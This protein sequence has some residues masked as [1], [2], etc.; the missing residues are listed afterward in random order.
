LIRRELAEAGSTETINQKMSGEGST[1]HS[2]APLARESKLEQL[3]LS[4]I[5]L[6]IER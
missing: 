6:M 3:K 4:T 2:P 1:I 5:Q